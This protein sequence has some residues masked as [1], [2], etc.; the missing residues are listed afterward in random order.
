MNIRFPQSIEGCPRRSGALPAAMVLLVLVLGT[1]HDAVAQTPLPGPYSNY[2]ANQYAGPLYYNPGYAQYGLPGVG[3]SPWNPIVQ[4][5][6]NLGMRTARY[7]MYSAWAD[8]SNAAANLY[9]QQAVTQQI[10]NANAQ[11]A[12]QPHYDVETRAPRPVSRSSSEATTLL[13]KSALLKENGDVI[14]PANVPASNELDKARSGAE[15][16]IRIAVKEFEASGKASIS[17]VAE[18]KSQLYAYGKPALDQLARANREEAKK[19]LKFLA[20]LEQELN[21]LAGE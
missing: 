17:S 2:N 11:R 16:A 7:N 9:Y 12:M 10:Q 3:V 15:S 6:L 8:Q 1:G 4:A 21:K 20:S 5:Q 19:L 14:W 18:A 13:S